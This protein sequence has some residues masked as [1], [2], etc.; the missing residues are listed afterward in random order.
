CLTCT[1]MSGIGARKVITTIPRQ[2]P[3]KQ[4]KT[5]RMDIMLNLQR[6]GCCVGA[7]S[8]IPLRTCAPATATG[9]SLPPVTALSVSVRRGLLPL[10]HSTTECLDDT[11]RQVR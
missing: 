2:S 5:K 9:T 4:V 7:H 3:G 8:S 11:R 1:E 6:P 10:D